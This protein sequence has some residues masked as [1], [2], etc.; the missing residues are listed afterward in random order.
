MKTDLFYTARSDEFTANNPILSEGEI[1]YEIDTKRWKMGN[2]NDA[3]STLVYSDGFATNANGDIIANIIPRTNTQ[4]NLKSL[5]LSGQGELSSATDVPSIVQFYGEEGSGVP[6][7]YSPMR[8]GVWDES[9]ALRDVLSSGDKS[10]LEVRTRY[11]NAIDAD[12]KT[13]FISGANGTAAGQFGGD[14]KITAGNFN[15]VDLEGNGGNVI[16]TAGDGLFST[17]GD[18]VVEIKSAGAVGIKVM[19]SRSITG[20]DADKH[21]A[22]VAFFD[23]V[24]APQ[25]DAAYINNSGTSGTGYTLAQVV[26]A[27]KNLGLLV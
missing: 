16:I 26:A 3:W 14:V 9:N 17:Y 11:T 12:A 6:Y 1:G 22:A 23:G 5:A 20:D 25:Q 10:N 24:G 2:G 8:S 4:S 19:N 7:V 27:L 18:G 13:L 15:N 21:Q